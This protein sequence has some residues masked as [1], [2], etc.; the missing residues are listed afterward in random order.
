MKETRQSRIERADGSG[1][2]PAMAAGVFPVLLAVPEHCRSLK[3]REKVVFLS[4]HARHALDISAVKSGAV[5]KDLPKD[6]SGAPLPEDGV[7]WS[8]SHKPGF[9][10]GVVASSP[11]GIDIEKV[12]ECNE[13]LFGKVGRDDEWD[14]LGG[15]SPETFFR[16]WTAKEAVLKTTGTGFKG[17]GQ[18]RIRRADDPTHLTVQS[19]GREWKVEHLFFS[20]HIAAVAAVELAVKWTL[21]EDEQRTPQGA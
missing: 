10:G 6:D 15:R 9:V 21:L 5:L 4:R 13:G 12:K 16:C 1:T 17:I 14:M 20:G 8:L 19:M 3:G 11:I 2:D 18:C 7:Y